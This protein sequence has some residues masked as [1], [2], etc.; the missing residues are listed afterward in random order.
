MKDNSV[1]AK[2]VGIWIRV[3]TEDQAQ[4]ES[5]KHHEER[6]RLY[7]KAKGWQVKEMYDLAGVSGKSVMQHP[8]AKRMLADIKR[9]HLTG[10]IFSKLARLARNT[11][12]LLDFSEIFRASNAD[13]ISLQE[14]IDTSSPAGRLFYTM[15]AAMAQWERE[16]IGER[17]KASIPIRAKLG[18]PLGGNSPYGYRWT[19][20]KL[21]QDKQEAPVRKLAFELFAKHR[22]KLAVAKELNDAGYR[23]RAGKK[24][25]DIAIN[26]TLRCTSAR[27]VYYLNRTRK[28]GSWRWEEKP[29]EDWGILSV[30]PIVSE[31][32]WAECNQILDERKKN[33]RPPGKRPVQLFGG[34]AFCACGQKMYVKQNSPKYVCQKCLNKIPIVDLEAI[35]VEDLK[36]FFAASDQIA[37]HI[38]NANENLKEKEQLLASHRNEIQKVRDE[39]G[40]TYRLFQ[41]GHLTDQ[42]FGEYYK[43]AEERLNQLIAE[44]P[45]LESE[46]DVLKVTNLSK[47]EV[48]SEARDLYDRWPDLPMDNKRRIV[49]S[50]IEK[51]TIGKDEINITLSCLPSSEEMVKGQLALSGP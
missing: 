34:L 28:L 17:V 4:G 7:A 26:R 45:L 18:K 37:K 38:A 47:E 22:R 3:S 46:V 41:N 50:I 25:S 44:L 14:S 23:T 15:I 40:R 48:V 27:G 24:W 51:V 1:P 5:P 16:E 13:L 35:V 30:E 20:G 43:P 33:K 19:D 21:V 10:L 9:G 29:K 42:G 39:M 11:K 49:E 2:P 6:A 12:E 8:E 36:G 31:A 32:L